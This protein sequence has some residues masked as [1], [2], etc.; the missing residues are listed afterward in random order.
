MHSI[1]FSII[2]RSDV[3]FVLVQKLLGFILQSYFSPTSSKFQTGIIRTNCIDCL[4]RTNVVQSTFAKQILKQFV[5]HLGLPPIGS[6]V[7]GG[8][9]VAFNGMWANNGDQISKQ[10]AGTSALKGDFVRSVS[11]FFFGNYNDLFIIIIFALT[12]LGNVIGV[13]LLM[14]L[15]TQ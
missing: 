8:L 10:Y 4:D 9:D 1:V 7:D 2:S 5:V 15:L 14:T 6:G 11:S 3:F 13:V 12:E